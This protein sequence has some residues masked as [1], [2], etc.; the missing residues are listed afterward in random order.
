MLTRRDSKGFTVIELMMVVVII[1]L[2]AAITIPNYMKFTKRAKE[3]VVQENVHMLQLAMEDYCV[4]MLGAYPTQAEEADLLAKLP[5]GRYPENPFSK[6]QTV[7]AWQA[8]P[9]NPGE[10]AIFNLPGGG[11]RLRAMGAS[12]LLDDIEVGE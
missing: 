5:M 8:D 1:G 12:E 4:E 3:A 11:Y 10:I 9:A 2:I 6:A 7:L